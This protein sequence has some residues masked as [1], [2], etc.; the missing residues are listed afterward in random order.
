M[1]TLISI[2]MPVYN[3]EKYISRAIQSVLNQ[4]Y[5]EFELLI[6][7]DASSDQS[8]NRVAEFSDPRIRVL[9]R[10][11]PGPGGY[12]ARN[13][14]I[15]E[16]KGTWVALLDADDAWF[17]EHLTQSMR[18]ASEFPDIPILSAARMSEMG[19][20]EKL[21]P[22]AKRFI[23]QG[24]QILYFSDYLEFACKG[25]RAMG[26]NS[27]LLKRES[28][29]RDSIFPEGRTDRSGDLYTWVELLARMKLMVWSPHV[30]SIS[31]RD[32]SHVSKNST[33]SIELFREMVSD[34]KPYISSRDE[35]YLQLYANK[36]IKYAWLEN[37]KQHM[38]VSLSQLPKS[39][40]WAHDLFYCMKWTL[41]SMLPFGLL[42]SL[43]RRFLT[44]K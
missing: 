25:L 22:F 32:A 8:L 9:R 7:D 18:I 36:M 24:P 14:G 11:N 12:A 21:D 2:I 13:H 6:V 30:A 44:D 39:F 17:P 31:Y 34:L 20:K 3:K 33:P 40:F 1:H 28:L 26:T 37:K 19:G 5:S 38:P 42:E 27:I 43:R 23:S 35:K 29:Y 10:L 41:I 16:A 15:R 4:T